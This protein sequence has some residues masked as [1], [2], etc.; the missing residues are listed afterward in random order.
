[1]KK[2]LFL[3]AALSFS[4]GVSADVVIGPGPSPTP[5]AVPEIDAASGGIA[6]ALLAGVVTF[7][8]ERRSRK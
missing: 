2:V 3:V 8:R 1:M 7:M 5:T 6:I 4:A